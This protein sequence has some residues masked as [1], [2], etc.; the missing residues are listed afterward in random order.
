MVL[1]VESSVQSKCLEV[2]GSAVFSNLVSYDRSSTD[3]Q[4]MAWSLLNILA[5]ANSVDLWFVGNY[6]NFSSFV[7]VCFIDFVI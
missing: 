3:H 6:V 2:V 5:E 7:V 1:D 4:N